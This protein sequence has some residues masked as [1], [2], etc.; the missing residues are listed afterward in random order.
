[1]SFRVKHPTGV[2]EPDRLL[3]QLNSRFPHPDHY[4][5]GFSGGLD[6]SVLLH[7]LASLREQLPGPLSAIHVDHALQE[8]SADWAGHCRSE[9]ELLGVPLTSVLVDAAPKSGESPE[10]AARAA[11]YAAIEAALSP[12][13]MLLT[14]HHLDDQA[15]TLLLQLLRGAGVEGLAAMPA[16]RD[17]NAGWHARPLLGLRR[18]ALRAWAVANR[19]RWIEDPSNAASVA[20]RNYLR[21]HVM[22][23]LVA[24]WPGAP[25]SIARSAAHCADAADSISRLAEQDLDMVPGAEPLPA[26]VLRGLPLVRARNVLRYWLRKQNAPA[27]SLRRLDDALDQLCHAR[28]DAA[29]RI[30]WGDVEMRRFRGKAWLL[31]M[32]PEVAEKHTVDWVGETMRLGPGLGTVRR[33]LAPGGIDPGRWG[34]GSVQIGYRSAD[35][36]CRPAGRIGTRPFKKIAQEFAIPPWWREIVPV[37]FIDGQPA[38]IANYCV[39]EPFA[40]AG[41][42]PGWVIEWIPD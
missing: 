12:R 26:G 7:V 9:C 19:L 25:E 35:L 16:N 10:A 6:S 39:C 41:G 8:G 27:L 31:R 22:P 5:V 29:V 2:F 15:E 33:T 32:P 20:D 3:E 11:R 21:H 17:W 13:A 40:A 34:R 38:A 4:W 42:E 1:V 24:R 36:R 14:A 23:G 18:S 28:A 37:V 30:A